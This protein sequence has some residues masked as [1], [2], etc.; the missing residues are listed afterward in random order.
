MKHSLRFFTRLSFSWMIKEPLRLNAKRSPF[1]FWIQPLDRCFCSLLQLPR[2]GSAVRQ[3]QLIGLYDRKV[4]QCLSYQGKRNCDNPERG[5][6]ITPAIKLKLH[7]ALFCLVQK[8]QLDNTL[9]AAEETSVSLLLLS[10]T[11][12]P[13]SALSSLS[14]FLSHM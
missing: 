8:R 4:T 12:V 10:L 3:R 2:G 13:L 6:V 11:E 1:N 5:T 7:R 9:T 14:P